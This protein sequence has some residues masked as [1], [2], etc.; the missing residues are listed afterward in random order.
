MTIGVPT[1]FPVWIQGPTGDVI[2]CQDLLSYATLAKQGYTF[3][4]AAP[5]VSHPGSADA[6]HPAPPVVQ[7][8]L[9]PIQPSHQHPGQ[10]R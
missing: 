3:D 10:V 5:P 6:V 7:V 8:S 1:S 9:N 2:Q 4:N